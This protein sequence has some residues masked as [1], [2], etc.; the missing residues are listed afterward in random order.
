MTDCVGIEFWVENH[1]L[2]EFPVLWEFSEILKKILYY[3][4][5]FFVVISILY[6][7]VFSLSCLQEFLGSYLWISKILWNCELVRCFYSPGTWWAFQ[8][9]DSCPSTSSEK[10]PFIH[11]LM[12]FFTSVFS[13]SHWLRGRHL[14][15]FLRFF[16]SFVSYFSTSLFY[17]WGDFLE[18]IFHTFY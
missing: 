15:L 1:F 16:L 3:L 5:I 17:F 13:A 14:G 9:E 11:S 2:S 18:F 4:L 12:T 6:T 7:Y 8:C 10:I